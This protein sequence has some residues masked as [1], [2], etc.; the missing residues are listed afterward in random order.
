[1]RLACRRMMKTLTEFAVIKRD[2][3]IHA[4]G[5]VFA[6]DSVVADKA[7]HEENFKQISGTQTLEVPDTAAQSFGATDYPLGIVLDNTRSIR[8]IG[9]LPSNAFS[10]D[11]YISK[12]IVN[13]TKLA[14]GAQERTQD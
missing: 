2:T 3:P 6:D 11:G 8:F 4:Y 5:L 14:R 1:M 12:V 13:M 9:L 10:G 7:A